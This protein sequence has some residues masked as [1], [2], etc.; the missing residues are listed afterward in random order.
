MKQ[1]GRHTLTS[2][3]ARPQSTNTFVRDH[4]CDFPPVVSR[5]DRAFYDAGSKAG[6]RILWKDGLKVLTH[7]HA[8]AFYNF[9]GAINISGTFPKLHAIDNQAFGLAKAVKGRNQ[10]LFG[11][12]LP[13]LKELHLKAF[14][15]YEG[16]LS[17]G[18]KYPK[19]ESCDTGKDCL[20]L[21]DAKCGQGQAD[22]KVPALVRRVLGQRER[23][24]HV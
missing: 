19:L 1:R 8:F 16:S 5:A 17:F 6:S 3:V 23:A 2:N 4:R 22:C 15:G 7:I 18:G 13:S 14:D 11:E 10:I 12:G 9:K 21:V 24:V 20:T